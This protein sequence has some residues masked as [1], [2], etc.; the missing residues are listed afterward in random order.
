MAEKKWK[1]YDKK[2]D[3]I[4]ITEKISMTKKPKF[5][6]HCECGST[7]EVDSRNIEFILKGSSKVFHCQ[8]C[9]ERNAKLPT[10]G[11][12]K[13]VKGFET[14]YC[15]CSDG[16]LKNFKQGNYLTPCPDSSGYLGTKCG[17][18]AN[19]MVK[20][21][22]IVAEH[23]LPNPENMPYVNFK[24]GDKLN[25]NVDNLFWS[26]GETENLVGK[27]SER[28]IVVNLH[29][30][31]V[32]ERDKVVRWECLCDCGNTVFIQT[33]DFTSGHTRS[34]GCLKTDMTVDRNT[35]H[36]LTGTPEYVAWQAAKARTTNPN[37]IQSK[38]YL[39][40]GI[41]MEEPWF[42]SFEI[43]LKDMGPRPTPK[44]SV[45]RVNVNGNYCKQN[46]IWGTPDIQAFNQRKRKT[47]TSGR[48]GV[49]W[50]KSTGKWDVRIKNQRLF[51]TED[52][53]LAC[54]IREEAELHYYGFTKE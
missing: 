22:R 14:R 20:I 52:F 25:C 13:W 31:P 54:F 40:R 43:F 45:E 1:K 23:F 9:F 29:R 32:G 19:T 10:D 39:G 8:I 7:F 15:I 16:R 53:E 50:V 21:H 41:I 44:H 24:D 18:G 51:Q 38:D 42:S 17:G 11:N 34:C 3:W 30:I 2:I 12:W 28:L 49:Y 46:C 4:T 6:G 48:T 27:R 36:G 35:I 33:T 37:V 5:R 26:Y 47:N